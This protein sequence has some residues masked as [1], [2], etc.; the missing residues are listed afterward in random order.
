MIKQF[1][2]H[3]VNTGI[4]VLA[5]SHNEA[6]QKIKKI[7]KKHDSK[8]LKIWKRTGAQTQIIKPNDFQDTNTVVHSPI[9]KIKITENKEAPLAMQYNICKVTQ[10]CR[11]RGILSKCYMACCH[12]KGSK[13]IDSPNN[14]N[15][16]LSDEKSKLPYKIILETKPYSIEQGLKNHIEWIRT[17]V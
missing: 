13:F 8:S 16:D 1:M 12:H 5:E 3:A 17:R 9:V 7:L 10:L 15:P 11:N 4:S 2:F 14:Y 6:Y